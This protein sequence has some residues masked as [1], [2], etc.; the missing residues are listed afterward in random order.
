MFCPAPSSTPPASGA[1]RTQH[2]FSC[3]AR[4]SGVWQSLS[5]SNLKMLFSSESITMS[6]SLV[7][8]CQS[9]LRILT[10]SWGFSGY[11][12]KCFSSNALT[13]GH[14]DIEHGF[15]C[16]T[17]IVITTLF[18]NLEPKNQHCVSTLALICLETVNCVPLLFELSHPMRPLLVLTI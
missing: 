1:R 8:T 15:T 6:W 9:L 3:G 7:V 17:I 14:G 10:T 4:N 16:S 18:Q 5:C 2:I 13:K 11:R 12:E